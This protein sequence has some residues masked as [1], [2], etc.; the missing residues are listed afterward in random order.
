METRMLK[1]EFCCW[2]IDSACAPESSSL[3]IFPQ[4]RS[5][6]REGVLRSRATYLRSFRS[7]LASRVR[8]LSGWLTGEQ[9]TGFLQTRVIG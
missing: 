7:M 2:K 5:Q 3:H 4:R 1:D 6:V 9:L 8:D